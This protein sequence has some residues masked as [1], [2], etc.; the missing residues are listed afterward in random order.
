MGHSFKSNLG[1]FKAVVGSF[2][3]V[4]YAGIGFLIVGAGLGIGFKDWKNSGLLM[5]IG[6]DIL[7]LSA[8]LPSIYQN[9][10]LIL[11]LGVLVVPV[12]Y[13]VRYK[14]VKAVAAASIQTFENLKK[15]DPEKAKEQSLQIQKGLDRKEIET[16]KGLKKVA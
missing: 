1:E 4:T 13:W 8:I 5:G 12:V 9:G 2:K 6:A 10:A 7:G 3:V 15:S 14:R 11:T 16:A